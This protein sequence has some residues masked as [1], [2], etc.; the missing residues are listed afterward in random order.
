MEQVV[1][2]THGTEGKISNEPT[3]R[4]LYRWAPESIASPL[5][6]RYTLRLRRPFAS[7]KD[8]LHYTPAAMFWRLLC[9]I[10]TSTSNHQKKPWRNYRRLLHF[11]YY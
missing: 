7:L 1:I 2:I 5:V 4:K 3:Y 6:L 10:R 8:G 11:V 9:P